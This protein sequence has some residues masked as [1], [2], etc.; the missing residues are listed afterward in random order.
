[1][2]EF[3]PWAYAAVFMPV[4]NIETFGQMLSDPAEG[5]R[6]FLWFETDASIRDPDGRAYNVREFVRSRIVDYLEATDPGL[7]RSHRTRAANLVAVV[8]QSD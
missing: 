5:R 7:C 1:M 8:Q 3:S 4:I 2:L 6:A